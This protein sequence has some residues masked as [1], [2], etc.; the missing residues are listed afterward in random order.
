[1]GKKVL[2]FLFILISNFIFAT[3]ITISGAA[4]LKEYLEKNITEFKKLNPEVKFS[5]NLGGS[6]TLK[7]QV[8]NGAPVDIIFLADESMMSD[9]ENKNLIENKINLLE[10]RLVLIKNKNIDKKENYL[11]AI[12]E[13]K[14]VPAGKYALEALSNESLEFSNEIIY[15]KDVRTVLNY[16]ELGE[17]DFGIVY[18]SDC[19]NL[20]N[21]EIVKTFDSKSHTP[22]IYPIGIVSSSENKNISQNFINFLK[23]KDW[24]D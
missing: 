14:S 3:E 2:A 17:V 15:G 5:L 20:K 9:L 1:M 22:I 8:E 18:L 7:R 13:P 16:V 11:L 21:S 24:N 4:S 23:G 12:G 10:N 19:K 6:G